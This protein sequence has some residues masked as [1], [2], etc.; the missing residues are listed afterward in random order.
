MKLFGGIVRRLLQLRI[1]HGSPACLIDCWLELM[2]RGNPYAAV[3]F[4]RDFK[5]KVMN[6]FRNGSL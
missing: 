6:A 4:I 5:G 3:A 2:R 1:M